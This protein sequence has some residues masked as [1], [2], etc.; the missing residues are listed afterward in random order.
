MKASVGPLTSAV[1]NLADAYWVASSAAFAQ[2]SS[3]TGESFVPSGPLHKNCELLAASVMPNCKVLPSAHSFSAANEKSKETTK[4]VGSVTVADPTRIIGSSA[5]TVKEHVRRPGLFCAI[6]LELHC[7]NAIKAALQTEAG[8]RGHSLVVWATPRTCWRL[9]GQLH[10][11]GASVIAAVSADVVH[12]RAPVR[13]YPVDCYCI[14]VAGIRDV[15]FSPQDLSNWFQ[16]A[17]VTIP[18][19]CAAAVFC[20]RVAAGKKLA[21]GSVCTFKRCL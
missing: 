3:E 21:N 1:G 12:L 16:V 8:A 5:F 15:S 9:L 2:P 18:R 4:C 11:N 10:R 7:S 6:C 13:R 17:V 19:V 14:S 20:L